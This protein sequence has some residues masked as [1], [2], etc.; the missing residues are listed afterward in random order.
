MDIEELKRQLED[1]IFKFR[2]DKEAFEK[3]KAEV[4]DKIKQMNAALK[5][6]RFKKTAF[7]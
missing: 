6:K 4:H 2:L 1:D 3:H 7:Q 5:S